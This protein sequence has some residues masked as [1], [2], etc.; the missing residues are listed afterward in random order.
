LQPGYFGLMSGTISE[1]PT[2]G[3]KLATLMPGNPAAGRAAIQ[4]LVCLFDPETG[5]PA[6]I[7]DAAAITTTRTA[8]A[9]GFATRLLARPDAASHGIFGTGALVPAHVDAIH[10]ARPSVARTLI[11]GRDPAKAQAVAQRE[12][13]RTGR[14]VEAVQD[15]EL[16]ARCDIVSTMTAATEPV[17]R[18]AWLQA[19]AH[20]NLVGPH[21]PDQRE[22][23]TKTVT[24]SRVYVDLLDSALREAGEL[25]IPIAEGVFSKEAIVGEIG[26]V[27]AGSCAGRTTA[28][29][30]TLYKSLGIVAQD[31]FAA[32]A[33]LERAWRGRRGVAV[34]F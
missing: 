1:P 5:A 30:I 6:A 3:A 4:G 28:T 9:S 29:Q 25:L 10:A 33:V 31:L 23:D 26:Q 27:A 17:L 11:W 8:A 24:R 21:R 16:A 32:Q 22:A 15:P 34:A 2:I 7:L 18:G 13:A 19:G 12:A 20:L 14:P